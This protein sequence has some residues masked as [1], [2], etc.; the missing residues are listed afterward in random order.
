MVA[1]YPLVFRRATS[2]PSGDKLV[3][4]H[5]ARQILLVPK[6]GEVD[7]PKAWSVVEHAVRGYKVQAVV[8]PEWR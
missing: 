4:I 2:I 6:A 8:G 3:A 7:Y 5:L 1:D